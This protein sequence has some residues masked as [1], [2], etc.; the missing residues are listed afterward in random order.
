[1]RQGTITDWSREGWEVARE[2]AY[3]SLFSRSL[4][5]APAATRPGR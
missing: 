3:G 4:R 1:M 5:G 2:F